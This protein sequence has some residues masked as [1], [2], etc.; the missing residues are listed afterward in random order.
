MSKKRFSE[1]LDDLL[2]DINNVETEE[3]AKET[4]PAASGRSSSKSFASDLDAVL[5]DA[6]DES[7]DRFENAPDQSLAG[8][9]KTRNTG[10]N[11]GGLDSLIRQTIDV[12]ELTRDEKTGKKR[13]TVA[14][15]RE[16]LE[17]LKSIAKLENSYLKDI[18]VE[19]IDEFLQDYI[20]KN[21][22]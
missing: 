2:K 5:N 18:V 19:I 12:S 13:L 22:L 21:D 17:K 20:R 4:Q 9:S 11:L 3:V 16:K 15:D 6:L 7:L 10:K 8:K 14:V 1:G